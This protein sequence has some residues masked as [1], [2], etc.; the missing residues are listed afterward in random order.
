MGSS[1]E[2][3]SKYANIPS[4]SCCIYI[5]RWDCSSGVQSSCI[6]K[7]NLKDGMRDICVYFLLISVFWVLILLVLNPS[8]VNSTSFCGFQPR[9]LNLCG[10]NR[11]VCYIHRVSIAFNLCSQWH[12]AKFIAA[13]KSMSLVDMQCSPAQADYYGNKAIFIF[14][15]E[16]SW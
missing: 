6:C 16:G 10:I 12:W 1:P 8:P 14:A 4:R 2:L 9:K 11:D 5:Y 15:S 13:D 3:P 7:I